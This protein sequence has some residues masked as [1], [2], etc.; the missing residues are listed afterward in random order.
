MWV[1]FKLK[2][3]LHIIYIC[4]HQ[5]TIYI[6]TTLQIGRST[7]VWSKHFTKR[8]RYAFASKEINFNRKQ[9]H[10]F[11][12]GQATNHQYINLKER[13]CMM[14]TLHL[15][16]FPSIFLYLSYKIHI[17]SQGGGARCPPPL[18]PQVN[19]IFSQNLHIIINN[20]N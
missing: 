8:T 19:I 2:L 5:F 14:K 6:M 17:G 20:S 11:L 1:F 18:D 16:Y 12:T 15:L 3:P 4:F 7:V 10:Q 9:C 13:C